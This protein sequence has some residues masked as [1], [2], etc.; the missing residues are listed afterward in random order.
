MT[1]H[2]CAIGLP[3]VLSA[4]CDSLRSKQSFP[5][6]EYMCLPVLIPCYGSGIVLVTHSYTWFIVAPHRHSTGIV[7][8]ASKLC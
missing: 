2:D 4:C 1:L 8:V 7:N 6:S 5:C 3:G